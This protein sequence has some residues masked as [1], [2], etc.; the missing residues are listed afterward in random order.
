MSNSVAAAEPLLLKSCVMFLRIV[1][2]PG[3]RLEDIKR[4]L[5]EV[6]CEAW[7]EPERGDVSAIT[8]YCQVLRAERGREGDPRAVVVDRVNP[9]R[10]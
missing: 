3:E 5:E 6:G 9:R 10:C 8:K 1:P 7:L 2:A 4:D